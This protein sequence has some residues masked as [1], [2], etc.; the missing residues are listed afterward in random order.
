[1]IK[2]FAFP[3]LSRLFHDFRIITLVLGTSMTPHFS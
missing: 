1:M 3:E 2:Y